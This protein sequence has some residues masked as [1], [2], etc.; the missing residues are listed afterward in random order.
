MLMLFI[1]R[2]CNYGLMDG[3]KGCYIQ[4][5]ENLNCFESENVWLSLGVFLIVDL[6][7]V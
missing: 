5:V 7:L 6:L 3:D 4:Y 1:I 2:Y